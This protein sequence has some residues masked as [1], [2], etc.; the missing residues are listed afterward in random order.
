M[1]AFQKI[2]IKAIPLMAAVQSL[3]GYVFFLSMLGYFFDKKFGTFPFIFI[4]LLFAGLALGFYQISS[5][6]KTEK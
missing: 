1:N 5:L 4:L 2:L 6:T 3:F